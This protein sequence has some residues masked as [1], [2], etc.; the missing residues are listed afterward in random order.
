MPRPDYSLACL[1]PRHLSGPDNSCLPP[2]KTPAW[3]SL[4]SCL[5]LTKTLLGP[6]YSLAC[7]QHLCPDQTTLLPHCL[8]KSLHI[9]AFKFQP[10]LSVIIQRA[11]TRCQFAKKENRRPLGSPRQSFPALLKTN[12]D[13]DPAPQMSIRHLPGGTI[14]LVRN[15]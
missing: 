5:P 7:C 1:P 6:D 12:C 14:T 2:T 3:A 10:L 15:I 11:L 13:L 8:V 4:L 9:V